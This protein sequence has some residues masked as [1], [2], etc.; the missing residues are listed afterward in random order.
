MLLKDAPTLAGAL[1][2][3]SRERFTEVQQGLKTLGIPFLL[4][5]RLVRGLDYTTTLPLRSLVIN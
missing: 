5:P 4:N 2:D 1:C 3:E